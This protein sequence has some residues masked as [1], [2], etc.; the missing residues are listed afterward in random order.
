MWFSLSHLSKDRKELFV[1]IYILWKFK[2]EYKL[3][4]EYF[5]ILIFLIIL[6]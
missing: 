5:V 2:H 1:L 4:L 3:D 6:Q